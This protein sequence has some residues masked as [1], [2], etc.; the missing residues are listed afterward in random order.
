MTYLAE[1]ERLFLRPASPTDWPVFR[2]YALSERAEL[3][4][5]VDTETAAWQGFA[6][7]IGHYVIRG[8]AP[9]AIVL[10]EGGDRAIGMAGPYF[11]AG[12]P[13]PELGWQ[14]WDGQFEGKGYAYEAVLTARRWSAEAFGWKCMVSY[15]K[16]GNERSV[17]LA[18]R[19]G[20]IRD[21]AAE[22]RADDSPVWRHPE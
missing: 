21:E 15:I 3:S 14:I 10:R 12:W 7:L 18:E 17:L 19:L 4:M 8:F 13:E 16:E 22:R 5:G 11:P 1:S 6:H 2:N 20:C 9:L